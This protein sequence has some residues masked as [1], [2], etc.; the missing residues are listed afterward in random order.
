M[1][2][3]ISTLAASRSSSLTIVVLVPLMDSMNISL[4]NRD[5]VRLP[6]MTE[7][8]AKGPGDR[9]GVGREPKVSTRSFLRSPGTCRLGPSSK[10]THCALALL[11]PTA[12][13][14]GRC[15]N[16]HSRSLVWQCCALDE[17]SPLAFSLPPRCPRG[18]TWSLSSPT[19]LC[20]DVPKKK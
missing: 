1:V 16:G 11:W 3:T 6:I 5:S 17:G 14:V 13:L 15:K 18:S 4:G 20:L 19:E 12:F 10:H 7:M 8:T 2:A 9:Q